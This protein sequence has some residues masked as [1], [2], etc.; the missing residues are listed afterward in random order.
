M[1]TGGRDKVLILWNLQKYEQMRIIR[2]N[3]SIESVIVLP[4][5][6]DLP[7][8][9]VR[10]PQNKLYVAS[11]GGSIK[12]WEMNTARLVCAQETEGMA[13]TQMLYNEKVLSL[14]HI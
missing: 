5:C 14:I 13:I 6:M 10:L 11:A 1:V 3:E 9:V 2:V 4:N 8:G 7:A 12:I